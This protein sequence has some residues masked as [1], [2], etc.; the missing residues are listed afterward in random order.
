MG[1]PK[2][3]NP[4]AFHIDEQRRT[5]TL[6]VQWLAELDKRRHPITAFNELK[7]LVCGEEA[8]ASIAR[9]IEQASSSIDLVCWGFDPG[10][11]L[12]RG[13]GAAGWPRGPVYGSLL[14]AAEGRG[15]KVRLLVW[16]DALG[17]RKQNNLPGYTGDQ[18]GWAPAGLGQAMADG[19]EPL[20]PEDKRQAYCE[21]WWRDALAPPRP[22]ERPHRMEVLMRPGSSAEEV[23]RSLNDPH[24]TEDPISADGLVSERLLVDHFAT[25]HQKT[26]LIDYGWQAGAS[27]VGYVMGLNSL[28]DYWDS[29]AHLFDDPRRETD[30]ARKSDTAQALG[31]KRAVS[32]DPYRDYACRLRG[33]AL[34]GVYDNFARAWQRAGGKPWAGDVLSDIAPP[35]LPRPAPGS[36]VQILCTQPQ[37]QDKTI[38]NAYWQATSFAR[39]Y[40]YI[41]NQ[42]FFYERWVRHLKAMRTTFM[43][44]L[45][46]EGKSREQCKLLHLFAVIPW[47]EDDG[48]VPRT[49]DT[50][51]SLGEGQ[52]LPGQHEAMKRET[53]SRQA[54]DE[55]DREQQ[56]IVERHNAKGT[57]PIYELDQLRLRSPKVPRLHS[58]VYDSAAAVQVP[59]KNHTTGELEGLGLK[60]L[61]ARLVT[62]NTGKPLPKPEQNYRQVY[63][64]SKLML[65]DDAFF[66]LG[67]ANLNVRSMAA[68]SELNLATDDHAEA[69]KLRQRVWARLGGGYENADG[70]DGSPAAI[71]QA[72]ADWQK[73]MSANRRAMDSNGP[74]TGHL[75]PFEDKRVVFYRH[76]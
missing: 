16:Y 49:Y 71:K 39:N 32:R 1:D 41:E 35:R 46:E 50:V 24:S 7:P 2:T 17:S 68:D 43:Q 25:H 14:K 20:T 65:I 54:W 47:P 52:S 58:D 4:N 29:E 33:P 10:M 15:V 53:E 36:R 64:H 9:D 37:E 23:Q 22:G 76:G 34:K 51:K 13:D 63:I 6:T 21:Q 31:A 40:L 56:R 66:T 61:I 75:I 3:Q 74:V 72:F 28:T 11:E 12:E 60:V 42:Y 8:F 30:W 45:Q 67:S 18:R 73:V 70:G 5:A 38:K 19:I 44:W 27:G 48:M 62:H 69:R 57:N 55:Y 59:V 26:I